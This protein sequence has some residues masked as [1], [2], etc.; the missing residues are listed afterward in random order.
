MAARLVTLERSGD[1][2]EPLG[3][4]SI[5]SNYNKGYDDR[6]NYYRGG[7]YGMVERHRWH[8]NWAAWKTV[9]RMRSL[10]VEPT[11]HNEK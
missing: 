2:N 11:T 6:G 7:I 8:H 10:I 5:M 1:Y 4:T 3:C 9:D